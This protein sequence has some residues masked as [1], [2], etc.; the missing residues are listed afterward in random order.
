MYRI[1]FVNKDN[2]GQVLHS[3]SLEQGLEDIKISADQISGSDYFAKEPKRLEFT[4]YVDA[5]IT[6]HILSGNYEHDRYIS[7]FEVR[8][9]EHNS[10]FFHGIIDTSFT[11]FDAKDETVSFTCYDKLR[12][13]TKFAEHKMVYALVQGYN[14]GFCMGF[15]IQGIQNA[16]DINIPAQWS[17]TYSPINLQVENLSFLKI[18]WKEF[19]TPIFTA[20]WLMHTC[21]AGFKTDSYTVFFQV[22]IMT[23]NWGVIDLS[24]NLQFRR[25]KIIAKTFQ[26]FNNICPYE[27]KNMSLD[28]V[29]DFFS[30]PN[31]LESEVN[32]IIRHY[33]SPLHSSLTLEDRTY[34]SSL[35]SNSWDM[36]LAPEN[37]ELYLTGNAIA[38]NVYAKDF[39]LNQEPTEKLKVL[40][41]V[42]M[43]HNLTIIS[44]VYGILYLINKND[45]SNISHQIEDDDIIEF[46]KKRINRSIPDT[47]VFDILM[48]ETKTLKEVVS[49]YY[50]SYFAQ[51]WE[52]ETVIDNL[53]K[54]NLQIFHKLQLRGISLRITQ[55]QKDLKN[56]EFIVKGWQI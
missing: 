22:L 19:I 51:I 7:I 55:V 27:L 15:M 31:Q 47:S 50:Q 13:F 45:T 10:L 37:L 42:L 39:Y 30:N 11:V 29:T 48:G 25:R 28:I 18:K 20:G 38:V 14:P 16:I 36:F 8:A 32:H 6:E 35:D 21:F 53:S 44:D 24:N 2:Y 54:Y 5:W 17:N 4:C 56:D 46:K 33:Q 34:N 41:A 26:I 23:E 40:K 49:S 9:Y 43:L 1:D 52:I 12:L 3:V